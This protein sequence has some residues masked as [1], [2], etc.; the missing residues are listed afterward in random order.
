MSNND[1][2]YEKV[3][4]PGVNPTP[5]IESPLWKD[6]EYMRASNLALARQSDALDELLSLVI[7]VAQ[8]GIDND[9]NHH[10]LWHI[11]QIMQL[12]ADANKI[13]RG[14]AP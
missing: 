2:N 11:D 6:R 9:G 4:I 13:G 12:L 7:D 1:L 8:E 14:I 5:A 3:E 10:K